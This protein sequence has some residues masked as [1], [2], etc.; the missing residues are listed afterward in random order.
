MQKLILDMDYV[1]HNFK[2]YDTHHYVNYISQKTVIKTTLYR[3]SILRFSSSIFLI[4][5]YLRNI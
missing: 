3:N 1:L 5:I 2:Q 4:G